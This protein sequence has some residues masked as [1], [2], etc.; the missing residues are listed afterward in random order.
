[1]KFDFSGY[2]TKNGVR[3]SDGRTIMRDAFKEMDGKTVPVV[4][5]HIHDDPSNVLGHALLENRKDGVYC[6]VKLNG[7]PAGQDTKNLVE[8]GD[9]NSLSIYANQ[10]VQ[11]G[12]HVMHGTIREVSVVLSGANPGALIDNVAIQHSDGSS[13]ELEDEA[14]I[15]SGRF[16]SHAS[17]RVTEDDDEDDDEEPDED[18]AY[19]EPDDADDED[20]YDDEESEDEEPED[21][22]DDSEEDDTEDENDEGPTVEEVYNSMDDDQKAVTDFLVQQALDGKTGNEPETKQAIAQSALYHADEPTVQ[23]VIDSMNDDQKN[24]LHYLIGVALE[25]REQNPDDEDTDT[26]TDSEDE[27]DYDSEQEGNKNMVKHNAFSDARATEEAEN[28][29]FANQLLHDALDDK[30]N[31]SSLKNSI[32]VHADNYGIKNVDVLF[33]E[34]RTVTPT[35]EFASRKMDWVDAF[36]N[37]LRKSPFARIKSLAADITE[38]EARAKGYIKGKQKLNEIF[39][40]SKRVTTPQTIYKKQKLDRDDILDITDF[41]VVAFLKNEMQLMM[42]E[43]IARAVLVG[44]GREIGAEDKIDA[45]HIRPIWTDNELFAIHKETAAFDPATMTT[46]QS[47]TLSRSIITS[48][49]EYEGN[50]TPTMYAAPATVTALLLSEDKMGR[51]LYNNIQDL[52][53][54]LGVAAIVKVPVFRGLKRT[55]SGTEKNLACII[56]NPTDYTLGADKG[57]ETNFFDDF[58]LNVNQQLY[59]YE[60]RLSGALTHPKSAI[61]IEAPKA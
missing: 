11:N 5:Q 4:W 31:A 48:M 35:P 51:R 30:N 50:G 44:D 40:V 59:L 47:N 54:A 38:D 8:H 41:D 60:T 53:E 14:I 10:L 36:V 29:M 21:D 42:R 57:G 52:A 34:A 13:D 26:D 24:V 32:L 3:C 16:L 23:D 22:S 55:V 17:G 33:P 7:T 49:D 27:E 46:E 58:D 6:Y 61:V 9:V 56:V 25:Q 20:E 18:E 45:E 39:S 43:E 37:G 15:T 1:M 12:G 28:A 19:D 2:A